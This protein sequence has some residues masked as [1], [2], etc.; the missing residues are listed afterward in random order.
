MQILAGIQGALMMG[1]LTGDSPFIDAVAAEFM[2][3]LGY[4]PTAKVSGKRRK[5]KISTS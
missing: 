1:R 3:Y 2:R 4:A 5:P